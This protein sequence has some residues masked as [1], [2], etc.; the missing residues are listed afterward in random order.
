MYG[1]FEQ[2]QSDRTLVSEPLSAAGYRTAGFHSNPY[3][4]ADFGYDK[5]WD[6][7]FEGSET[8]SLLARLRGYARDRLDDDGLIYKTLKKLYD[9]TERQ[10]GIEVGSMY[11]TADDLTD[12]AIAWSNEVADSNDSRFLWIHYMDVHHPYVPPTE[13]QLAFRDEPISDRRSI[14]LR[15]KMLEQP[16][17]VTDTELADIIDLY[18]AEIRFVDSEISRLVDHIR[19]VWCET[20][21]VFTADHGEEFRDHGRFSHYGTFYDE[22][23]HVPFVFDDGG[24]GGQRHEEMVGLLDVSPTVLDCAG[25]DQPESYL[26]HSICRIVDG[27]PWPRTGVRSFRYCR[28]PDWKYIGNRSTDSGALYDLTADPGETMSV[29]EDHPETLAELQASVAEVRELIRDSE[30]E[31]D[32][33]EMNEDIRNRLQ[34]LGYT[35]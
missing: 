20:T 2:I 17:D 30:Q 22:V 32:D 14:K 3:L 18:D 12:Q 11:V 8:E 4:S 9:G 13:H 27:E 1:G 7:F 21:V 25:V 23:V 24:E 31:T 26:G 6:Q 15:R 10:T 5:G 28:T 35:E 34:A 16:A 33:V 19:D 29:A